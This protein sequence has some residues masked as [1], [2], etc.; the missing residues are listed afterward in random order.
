MSSALATEQRIGN[1][2]D[3]AEYQSAVSRLSALR[4]TGALIAN[5]IEELQQSIEDGAEK[6]IGLRADELVAGGK[7][8]DALASAVVRLADDKEALSGLETE[9]KAMSIAERRLV[10]AVST[11]ER[12]AKSK[13]LET[14]MEAYAGKVRALKTS[15]D[16]AVQLNAEVLEMHQIAR[17]QDLEGV[18]MDKTYL[19]ILRTGGHLD[20]LSDA[21]NSYVSKWN[22]HV[23]GLIS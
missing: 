1:W 15:L 4:K 18:A 13:V 12:S 8:S 23:A 22:T 10:T 5:K 6:T 17:S 9:L 16:T 21:P 7:K 2:Q 3:D 11:A 19:R 20:V 14:I